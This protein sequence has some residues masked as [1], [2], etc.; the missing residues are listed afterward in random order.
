VAHMIATVAGLVPNHIGSNSVHIPGLV[1]KVMRADDGSDIPIELSLGSVTP[2]TDAS[3]DMADTTSGGG[4][5]HGPVEHQAFYI[6]EDMVKIQVRSKTLCPSHHD[7]DPNPRRSRILS[8]GSRST[9][10]PVTRPT[11]RLLSETTI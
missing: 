2:T 4:S 9:S 6:R 5:D 10:L 11:S 3:F 7:A 1:V 8:S